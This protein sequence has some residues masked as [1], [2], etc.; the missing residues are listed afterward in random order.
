MFSNATRILNDHTL[1]SSIWRIDSD[2]DGVLTTAERTHLP[3][4]ER[5]HVHRPDRI[6]RRPTPLTLGNGISGS[7]RTFA[8]N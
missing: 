2:A 6:S 1:E 5:G 4:E 3:D 8:W 7:Q